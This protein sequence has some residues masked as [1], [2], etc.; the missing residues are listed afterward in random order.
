ML[1]IIKLTDVPAVVVSKKQKDP[2]KVLPEMTLLEI[3]SV[4]D[5]M[6]VNYRKA[7]TRC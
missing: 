6:P 1:K 5:V 2:E 7:P 4:D 3:V